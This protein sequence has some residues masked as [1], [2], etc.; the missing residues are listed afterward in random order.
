MTVSSQGNSSSP[1][2][3]TQLIRNDAVSQE[4]LVL[5]LRTIPPEKV[6]SLSPEDRAKLREATFCLPDL[7]GEEIRRELGLESPLAEKLGEEG[8][9]ELRALVEQTVQSHG[10][11]PTLSAQEREFIVNSTPSSQGA[12]KARGKKVQQTKNGRPTSKG[13]SRRLR[14]G[15]LF[16]VIATVAFIAISQFPG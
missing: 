3:P 6:Q 4:H 2:G 7:E 8:L 12:T 5:L 13:M 9:A 11:V 15:V 16:A 1:Q 10:R 14:I